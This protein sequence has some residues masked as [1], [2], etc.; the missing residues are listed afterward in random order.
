MVVGDAGSARATTDSSGGGR[1]EP[2]VA[3]RVLGLVQSGRYTSANRIAQALREQGDGVRT[4]VVFTTVATMLRD[5]RLIK[6]NDVI[7][8]GPALVHGRER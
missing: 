2:D 4:Q 7:E 6:I 3:Q 1:T 8:P 5:G